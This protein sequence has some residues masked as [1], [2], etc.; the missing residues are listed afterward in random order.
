MYRIVQRIVVV[1]IIFLWIFSGW[2]QIFHFP[3][4]I[5]IAFAAVPAYETDNT[6]TGEGASGTVTAPASIADDDILIFIAVYEKGSDI[7]VT[8]PSGFTS[9][10]V[11]D[12][13]TAVGVE[14]FYKRA[15]S[16]SGNYDFSLNIQGIKE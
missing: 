13:S 14:T 11:T 12:N 15:S 16:E 1:I 4:E 3:P 6:T 9:T 7:G 5:N 8:P 2:P 10:E